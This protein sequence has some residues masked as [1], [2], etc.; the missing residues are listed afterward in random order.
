MPNTID[1]EDPV[2]SPINKG[3][4]KKASH[5]L[6][7]TSKAALSLSKPKMLV[8]QQSISGQTDNYYR[9]NSQENL[10]N[11]KERYEEILDY[12][13]SST[14]YCQ[15]PIHSNYK[16]KVATTVKLYGN[17]QKRDSTEQKHKLRDY[18][19]SLKNNFKKSEFDHLSLTGSVGRP[20]TYLE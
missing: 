15:T 20:L 16:Q 7:D 12:Q 8:A 5:K 11:I 14:P 4:S 9:N 3:L 1:L 6:I 19:P 13:N 10:L 17:R 2:V 18:R